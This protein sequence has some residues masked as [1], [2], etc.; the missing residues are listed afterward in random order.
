VLVGAIPILGDMFDIA[1][2]SNR[3]NY[4]LLRLH[5]GEPH[6]HTWRDWVFL[7]LL[8]SALAI[9]FALPLIFLVWVISW[10]MNH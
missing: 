9:I 8:G 7:I 10:L 1:W 3:R 2:K 6:R 5:L 4:R